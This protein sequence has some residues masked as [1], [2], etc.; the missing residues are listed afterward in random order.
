[1]QRK[2]SNLKKSLSKDLLAFIKI[3]T[4]IKITQ[5]RLKFSFNLLDS[6]FHMLDT[7][8]EPVFGRPGVKK[9]LK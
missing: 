2:L 4:I 8:I 9:V 6:H 5:A 1:M 7:K 3:E